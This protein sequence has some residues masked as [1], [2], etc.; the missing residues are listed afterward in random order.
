MTSR[1]QPYQSATLKNAFEA[2]IR[3]KVERNGK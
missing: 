3:T 2:Q 1:Q